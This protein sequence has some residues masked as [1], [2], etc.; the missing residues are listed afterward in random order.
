MICP[1]FIESSINNSYGQGENITPELRWERIRGHQLNSQSN[2]GMRAI[3]VK[4]TGELIGQCS[5]HTRIEAHGQF[6]SLRRNGDLLGVLRS[7]EISIGYA[8]APEHWGH[9]YAPEAAKAVATDAFATSRVWRIV[10]LTDRPNRQSVRV[11]EKIGMYV[12][13]NPN[14]VDWPGFAGILYNPALS[15]PPPSGA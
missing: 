3:I 2:F 8:I 14:N 4:A 9:G 15:H 1:R 10:A 7:P 5:L 11:M 6:P 13:Q 12:E